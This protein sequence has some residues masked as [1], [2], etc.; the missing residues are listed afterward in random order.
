MQTILITGAASGLAKNV[1]DKIKDNEYFIFLTVRTNKQLER[2]REKYKNH[3]NIKCF[4]LDITNK[5]DLDKVKALDI[6]ILINNA[7]S[8][9]GGS[10][11]TIPMARLEKNFYTNVFGTVA[12]TQIV[13]QKMLQK[14]SGKIINIASLAGVMPIS[15]LGSY[16]ATKASIIKLS[17]VLRN[18]LKLLTDNIKIV[19]I[20]PGF[21]HTGFNQVMLENKYNDY[22][23]YFDSCIELIKARENLM[24][25]FLEHKSFNSI[26]DKI[27]KAIISDNPNF[28]YRAPFWQSIG[29]KIYELFH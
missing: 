1:I 20:E 17:I 25:R 10:V 24:L 22:H 15:F 14:D 9:E 8:G 12:L 28:I 21:Y 4:K 6:D 29:S 13:L 23:T 26:T 11:L 2:V 16:S 18:E 19:L 7:A 3:K 27:T 5:Q